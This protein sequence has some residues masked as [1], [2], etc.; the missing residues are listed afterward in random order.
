M[1]T[2]TRAVVFLGPTLP[3]DEARGILDAIY[4]PPARQAD[5]VSAVTNY[6]PQIVGLI[7]G[8]FAQS[9]SVWHKEILFALTQGVRVYGASS[10]GA[11]R[12]AE[13]ATFGMVG[14]GE[15][16]RMYANGEL[17]DDDEVALAHGD[18]DS[19]YRHAS[20]PMVNLR[21]TFERARDEGVI[22][23]D[24]CERWMALAK[25]IYFPERTL[26]AIL[27]RADAEGIPPDV[28]A[29][30]AKFMA[31]RYVDVKRQDAILLLRTI[32][33]LPDP[34]PPSTHSFDF[35]RTRFFEALYQRDRIVRHDGVDVS[36]HSI[37]DYAALH[38]PDFAKI[39]FEALNRALVVVLAAFLELEVSPED[40]EQEEVRLRQRHQLVDDSVFATWLDESDVSLGEFRNLMREVALCRRL[41]RWLMTRLHPMF[42]TK[43]IL[44]ELRLANCY[45]AVARTAAAHERVLQVRYPDFREVSHEGAGLRDLVME[46]LRQT[47]C[48]M[49]THFPEW[50]EEVGFASLHDLRVELLRS[51]LVHREMR[52]AAD[53]LRPLTEESS[54]Q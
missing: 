35:A 15:V 54:E 32:R 40:T 51:R 16:Y 31:T 53:A 26:A 5:L 14:I 39:N 12:A 25:A 10:L 44:D 33:D 23:A 47:D 42:N 4:L 20:E 7:D 1:T 18:A 6:R 36:L 50:A 11:L 34:L 3:I 21:K 29:R 48:S 9:L 49:D 22:D 45:G 41:H 52:R 2:T 8:I 19:A 38:L 37:A 17:T 24:L 13:T 46:H 43:L 30:V 27:R 28:V